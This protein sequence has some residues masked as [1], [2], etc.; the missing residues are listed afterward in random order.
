MPRRNLGPWGKWYAS[1]EADT[2]HYTD[3]QF[4]VWAGIFGLAVTGRGEVPRLRALEARYGADEVAFLIAEGRLKVRRGGAIH[5]VGWSVYQAQT[6]TTA[7]E[8]M[9][10]YRARKGE[11][12]AD[13]VTDPVTVDS[14]SEVPLEPH[15]TQERY[16][17]TDRH[18]PTSISTT[19]S[20]SP[21]KNGHA[22]AEDDEAEMPAIAWLAAH[23]AFVSPNG[24]GYH[25][26]L[27]TDVE[28]VGI[29]AVLAALEATWKAGART[30]RSLVLGASNLLD[31]IPTPTSARQAREAEDGRRE[32][33]RSSASTRRI[34]D[35]RAAFLADDRPVE[36]PGLDAFRALRGT[37][38]T[39]RARVYGGPSRIGE[40]LAAKTPQEP[41]KTS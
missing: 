11:P 28:R 23:K 33:E 24:N 3:R 36:G 16:G 18:V 6:D 12:P 22:P 2:E 13:P 4:R 29:V 37:L 35:E 26:K 39:P 38:A 20:S 34:L 14:I 25:R 41:E 19:S 15:S 30:D 7:A 40:V 5:V 21:K 32:S 8:R 1:T 10:R 31:P 17:V 27:I 9:R